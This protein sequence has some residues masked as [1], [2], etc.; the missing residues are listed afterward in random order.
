[1]PVVMMDYVAAYMRDKDAIDTAIAEVLASGQAV[2]GPPV[3]AFEEEFAAAV[4]VRHAAGVMSGTS[5]LV[6]ALRAMGIGPGDEVITVANSDIPTSHAIIH[7]GGRIVW[8]DIEPGSYNMDPE[9]L[10]ACITPK[11]RAIMPVHLYGIPADMEPILDIARRRGLMVLEDACL[12]AGARYQGRPV[13]SFGTAAA[14]STAPGKMLGGVG[15]G[16]II[17]TDQAGIKQRLNHLRNYGKEGDP[18]SGPGQ[19]VGPPRPKPRK[20]TVEVGYNERLDT[21]DAAVLRIRLRR[22]AADVAQRR[23]LAAGYHSALQGSDVR[24]P[25]PA[26]GSEPC[27]HVFPVRVPADRRDDVYR[28]LVEHEIEAALRYLP[29]NHLDAC[30]RYLGYREGSLPETEAAARDLICLQCHPF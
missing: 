10:E 18:Y 16:G 1:M 12:A 8:A 25:E 26:A 30:Y 11:T 5:A 14:F 24:L 9:R 13:G 20:E 22:L 2:M 3:K 7:A 27:W 21:I 15:S 28:G 6:L 23:A 4:G 17:T 19:Q 29:P